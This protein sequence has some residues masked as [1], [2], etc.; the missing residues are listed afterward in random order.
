V[1]FNV[2][3]RNTRETIASFTNLERELSMKLANRCLLSLLA[4]ACFLVATAI[5]AAAAFPGK[6]GRIAFVADLSGAYQLYT[7]NPDG[8]DQIRL[9]NLPPTSNGVWWPAYSPDGRQIAFSHDMTG[10]L[11]IYVINADGTGLRQLTKSDG[12][13]KLFARWS[14]DGQSIVF[15]HF[16]Q[17]LQSIGLI[18][19]DGSGAISDL[20][21]L[22]WDVYQPTFTP[23]GKE[24]L[25]GSEEGGLVSAIWSMRLD[26]SHRRRLTN[27][28]IEAGGPDVSPDGRRV[29]FYSQ[30]NTPRPTQV[31]VMNIDGSYLTQLTR[32]PSVSLD[33][34]YSPD[35]T[36]IAF[37][38]GESLEESGNLF[39][40]NADGSHKWEIGSHL[41][42]PENCFIGDCL[43]PDWGVKPPE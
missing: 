43:S 12:T 8:S 15:G 19:S 27:A 20:I 37:Q 3:Q 40:M 5:P 41:V 26:G 10:N 4:L 18:A 38:S 34:S 17:V 28:E 22:P 24:I 11:E 32:G 35:G 23:D 25:F 16:G 39:T 31:F 42:K 29:A 1:S 33:P 7:A 14:P 6:N 9:T 36:K 2:A 21:T 13:D 30:Q